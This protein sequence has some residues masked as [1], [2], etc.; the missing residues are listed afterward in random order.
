MKYFKRGTAVFLAFMT[1]IVVMLMTAGG[2]IAIGGNLGFACQA[3]FIAV[4][5]IVAIP[6]WLA[7]LTFWQIASPKSYRQF[8]N[9]CIFQLYDLVRAD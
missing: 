4:I 2:F 6:I 7:I 3:T 5:T 8:K 1:A 9:W